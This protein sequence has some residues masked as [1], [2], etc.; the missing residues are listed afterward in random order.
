M[1]AARRD[2][3]VVGEGPAGATAAALIVVSLVTSPP[4]P[5]VLERFFPR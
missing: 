5:P 3:V 4:G 1:S 2:V